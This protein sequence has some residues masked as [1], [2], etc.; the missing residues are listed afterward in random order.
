M[1]IDRRFTGYMSG[2]LST[3]RNAP[4]LIFGHARYRGQYDDLARE[5]RNR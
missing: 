2:A 1:S 5:W 3:D 4:Q